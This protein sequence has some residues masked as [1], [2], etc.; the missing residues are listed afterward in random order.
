MHF[1]KQQRRMNQL[2]DDLKNLEQTVCDCKIKLQDFID[3]KDED[4]VLSVNTIGSLVSTK[5]DLMPK[6]AIPD[7]RVQCVTDSSDLI[8][9][10]Q[11][12]NTLHQYKLEAI[13]PQEVKKLLE[14]SFLIEN[15]WICHLCNFQNKTV[16]NY[17]K[18][19]SS[20]KDKKKLKY[21]ELC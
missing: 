13:D 8:K 15:T 1:E 21:A 19:M 16:L 3:F 9:L 4:L 2:Y 7:L 18:E 14:D 12:V 5:I 17:K 20:D 11:F 6:I 10:D